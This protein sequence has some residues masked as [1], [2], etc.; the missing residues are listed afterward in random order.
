M[1]RG[2]SVDA[3]PTDT[4]EKLEVIQLDATGAFRRT[5]PDDE[6]GLFEPCGSSQNKRSSHSARRGSPF[7]TAPRPRDRPAAHC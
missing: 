6:R 2:D 4:A 7:G 3:L 1:H 5:A